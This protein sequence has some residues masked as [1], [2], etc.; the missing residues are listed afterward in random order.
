MLSP[1]LTWAQ[2]A[3]GLVGARGVVPL[4]PPRHGSLRLP[5]T[6]EVRLPGALLFQTAE[7]PLDQTVLLGRIG[8]RELLPEPVVPARLTEA[9]TLEDE[10]VVAP[11]HRRGS[12]GTERP[13]ATPLP[14]F[15]PKPAELPQH[16]FAVQ[17]EIDA[18]D[19]SRVPIGAQGAAAI[20]TGGG[21]LLLANLV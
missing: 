11:D 18:A 14:L 13:K 5:E 9:A 15:L 8:R 12:I 7:E 16:Q 10:A 2:V 21:R 3:E 17:I 20:Y 4:D 19:Q 6:P 1:V